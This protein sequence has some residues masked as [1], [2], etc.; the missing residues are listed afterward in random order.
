VVIFAAQIVFSSVW[1]RNFAFGPM[2]WFW[3]QLSYRKRLELRLN[4]RQAE[5]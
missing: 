2:E 4:N 3:R 1:L 5:A